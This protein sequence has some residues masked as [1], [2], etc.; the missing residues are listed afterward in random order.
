M[1]KNDESYETNLHANPFRIYGFGIEILFPTN[2]RLDGPET[3]F[4]CRDF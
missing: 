3:S 4:C 2:D 1:Q